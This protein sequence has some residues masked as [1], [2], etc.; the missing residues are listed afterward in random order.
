MDSIASPTGR[1]IRKSFR[2][3]GARPFHLQWRVVCLTP[4][5]PKD[6]VFR[7]SI[8][9]RILFGLSSFAFVRKSPTAIYRSRVEDKQDKK[10]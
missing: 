9:R 2:V 4:A 1:I 10:L 3:G 5:A 6:P 7:T 8:F